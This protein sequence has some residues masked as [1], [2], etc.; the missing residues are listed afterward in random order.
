MWT[1]KQIEAATAAAAEKPNGGK[2]I[3]PLFYKPEHQAFWRDVVRTAL[4]AA[5]ATPS[6]DGGAKPK[7]SPKEVGEFRDHCVYI[8]SVYTFMTRIW[9]DSDAAER[10]IMEA[11]APLFFED[12]GKVLGEFL[13]IAACRI[14]DPADAGRGRQ[15]FTAQLFVS[16]FAPESEAFKQ[17]EALR[18]RMQK[19][20]AVILPA[21]NKL[22]AHAD[23]DVITKGEPLAGGSWKEWDEFW[24]ALSDFV[25]ALKPSVSPSRSTPPAC[26]AMPRP[27]SRRSPTVSI[28]NRF[29]R[30]RTRLSGMPASSWR[31]LAVSLVSFAYS[32]CRRVAAQ[33]PGAA[34]RSV[35]VLYAQP[36][37]RRSCFR[38]S[39]GYGPTSAGANA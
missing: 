30:V 33:M 18:Q 28:S 26:W 3:D 17:L 32:G 13:V 4:D 34:S 25:S 12:I 24:S 37:C 38:L 9:K 6:S 23:H 19:L 1:D 8:R 21:R 15:N 36:S 20:R 29:S 35:A 11:V 5:K 31:C 22:G 27:C 7:M 10:K 16:S 14:T 39:G 2:F